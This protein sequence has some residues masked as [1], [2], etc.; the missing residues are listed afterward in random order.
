MKIDVGDR[1][2]GDFFGDVAQLVKDSQLFLKFFAGVAAD[3]DGTEVGLEDKVAGVAPVEFV[4]FDGTAADLLIEGAPFGAFGFADA[5]DAEVGEGLGLVEGDVVLV[6]HDVAAI[7]EEGDGF[8]V[9]SG[10][11]VNEGDGVTFLDLDS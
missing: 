5:D 1:I 8:D 7:V 9:G 2:Q 3:V 11:L 10:L 6:V 4:D